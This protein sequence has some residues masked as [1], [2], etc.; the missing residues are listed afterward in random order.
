MNRSIAALER[1]RLARCRLLAELRYR[2]LPRPGGWSHCGGQLGIEP[3]SL[4]LLALH[5]SSSASGSKTGTGAIARLPAAEWALARYW[6]WDCGSQLLGER[7]RGQHAA[8]SGGYSIDGRRGARQFGP[9]AAVGGFMDGPFEVPAFRPASSVRSYEV[10]LGVGSRHRELGGAD[11]DGPNFAG[12]RKE[13]GTDSRQRTAE[14][15]SP[16]SRDAPRSRVPR[17]RVERG[18]RRRLWRSSVPSH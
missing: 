10:R 17:R 14:K 11:I 3:T 1:Q 12:T 2:R 18:Q 8:D 9:L 5:S 13:T 16:R 6:G 7:D 4:A 15:A